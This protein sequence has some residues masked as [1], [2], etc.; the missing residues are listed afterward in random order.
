MEKKRKI[1][2]KGTPRAGAAQLPESSRA[3]VL[4]WLEHAIAAGEIPH[5]G[6]IP[7][8]RALAKL[9]GVAKNTAAAAVD[10]AVA[11]GSVV[12]R[13]GTRKRYAGDLR[14][15]TLA[16]A[17]IFVLAQTGRFAETGT[18]PGWSDDFLA[19]DIVRQLSLMGRHVSLL[20]SQTLTDED[21]DAVFDGRP[22]GVITLNSVK[23]APIALRALSRCRELGIP[24]VAYGNGPDLQGYDRVYSDHRA[25]SREL[26]RWLVSHGCRR[27]VPFSPFPPTRFWE[28]ERIAGYNEAMREAGLEPL[29]CTAF[30]SPAVLTPQDAEYFH[31]N[32]ALALSKLV[33]LR[34]EGVNPDA[35]L[36]LNDD[37]AKP[38]LAA[39]RDL[40]LVPN[41]DIL[42]AGYD[43]MVHNSG[44]DAFE[45]G[46]P[47]VTVDKHNERSVEDIVS[48]LIARMEGTL[49]PEPQARIHA[50]ELVVLDPDAS[51]LEHREKEK[52]P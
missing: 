13:E 30:S 34:R 11:R 22:G 32:A 9:L 33:A 14:S 44:Y 37:W 18:A 28:H 31:L 17:T 29:P 43:N 15:N 48:L 6:E 25:G 45:P 49:P 23:S 51:P 20:S 16:S 27:I 2:A 26:T 42:V 3:R 4:N 10:E 52:R 35:L 19:L 1:T 21:F 38:A 5:G 8:E 39:I 41:R 40:G 24:S 50:H 47:T 46:R 12:C 7:S 36:C